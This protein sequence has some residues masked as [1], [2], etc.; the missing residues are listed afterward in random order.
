MQ[1][2][3]HLKRR[4]VRERKKERNVLNL[5]FVFWWKNLL[6]YFFFTVLPIGWFS[7]NF[8][9]KEKNWK[10]NHPSFITIISLSI[11]GYPF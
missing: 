11:M 8:A 6:C 9:K 5:L 1:C 4:L 3:V 10:H 7:S 2:E